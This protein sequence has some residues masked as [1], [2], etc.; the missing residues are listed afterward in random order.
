MSLLPIFGKIFE[1][2][3]YSSLSNHFISNK[4]L[5]TSQS[6]FLPG[7]SCVAQLLSL[8]YEIQTQFD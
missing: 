1:R 6:G 2:V 4:P 7:D 5:T 3:I 8:I